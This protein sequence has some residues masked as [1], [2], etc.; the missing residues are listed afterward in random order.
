MGTGY[1]RQSASQIAPGNSITALGLENEFDAIQSAFASTTGHSHDD[2]SGEGPKIA[3]TT[4]ISGVLPVANGGFAGIHKVNGTLAPTVNE[5]SGDGYA[6]GSHWLDTTND[7]L[8]VCLDATVGAAV[9]QRYQIYDA[10]LLALAGLTSAADKGIQFTGAGTAGTFDLTAYAKTLLDDANEA[11]FKATLNA[12]AGVDFQA[13]SANLDEY[14]AVNPTAAGL[15]LLDDANAAAQLTTLGVSAYMQGLLDDA[16]EAT[17]KAS[18]NLEIGT[19]VQAYS[20]NL[21]EYAAVNPTAAGLAILDD[22]DASA[23][24]T[25]LGVVIGTNVQAYSANLDEYA[26]VNP[27]AAGLAILD[28]ADASAQ[29]TTL[30]LAIGTNVQA[31]DAGLAALAS[32]NTN[33]VLVQTA[34]NTFVGRTIT[35]TASQIT[36]TNG[37]G[38][39]GA[40]TLSLPAVAVPYGTAEDFIPAED[41][42]P[43]T[44][45]GAQAGIRILATNLQA[46]YYYAFDT[47]TSEIL[48]AKWLPKKRY[49]G[50]T[51]TFAPI[52]TAESGS[53]TVKFDLA[54]VAASNDD[55][56]DVAPGTL[57]GSTD[58]LLTAG[59]VHI[60]PTSSAITL[61]GTFADG[62]YVW[63]KLTRDVADTL[64]VDAQFLG[65]KIYYTT[66]QGNDA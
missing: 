59:D 54:G 26:A 66:D 52:W 3:L 38:V 11:T 14:A 21:D 10:E 43:P 17:L 13:Y 65:L 23:Q 51:I 22:A 58:T 34:D 56:L 40:P 46:L 25:T 9:W 35:G 18:V 5:D 45:N 36:V 29:R 8:Y 44:T 50:G 60:G 62:D 32:F 41:W 57:Q 63:L 24:R 12:E 4:S 48:W 19:D 15:A 28:D 1:T 30:G 31:Y 61:A 47:T 33:G 2:T 42:T 6:V 53:G 37:D 16:N 49:D 20:A 55:T 27:T 64:G 39:A 7:I